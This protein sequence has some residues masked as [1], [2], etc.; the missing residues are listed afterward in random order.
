LVLKAG[1]A[2]ELILCEGCAD[3]VFF[4]NV[5]HDFNDPSRVLL[6]AKMMLKQTGCLVNVD[7]KKEPMKLGPPTT[8]RFSEQKAI[9]LIRKAGFKID[10]IKKSGAYH[11][12]TAAYPSDR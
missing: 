7:W 4:G 12:M 6:N 5:L 1:R 9:S 3:F 11:Y 10:A 8:I 2:E